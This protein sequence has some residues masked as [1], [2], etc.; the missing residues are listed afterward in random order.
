MNEVYEGVSSVVVKVPTAD[1]VTSATIY[2]TI[3]DYD[4][5]PLIDVANTTTYSEVAGTPLKDVVVNLHGAIKMGDFTAEVITNSGTYRESFTLV[6]PYA[7]VEQIARAA[8]V[9]TTNPAGDKYRSEDDIKRVLHRAEVRQVV[10]GIRHGWD[11][12][13]RALQQ[14]PGD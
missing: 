12:D 9:Q 6:T 11:R 8:G 1:I 10:H 14:R 7:T 5:Q 2:Q 3:W 4:R 13:P